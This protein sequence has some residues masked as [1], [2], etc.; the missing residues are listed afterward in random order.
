MWLE[1]HAKNIITTIKNDFFTEKKQ[2]RQ[3]NIEMLKEKD[4]KY[5]HEHKE[6]RKEYR[7]KWYEENKRNICKNI[8]N[9]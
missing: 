3:D 2:Y 4:R 9:T 5:Y 8:E 7:K 6:Q 1:E